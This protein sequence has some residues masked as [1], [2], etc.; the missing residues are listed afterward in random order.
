MLKTILT[1][2]LEAGLNTLIEAGFGKDVRALKE[3]LFG[4]DAQSKR[5]RAFNL[6]FETALQTLP[7][8][9]LLDD[10]AF[11][12]EVVNALLDPQNGFNPQAAAQKFIQE[13]PQQTRHL[14]RFFNILEGHLLADEDWGELLTRYQEVRFREDVLATLARRGLPTGERPAIQHLIATEGSALTMGGGDA[15]AAGGILIKGG[16][17]GNVTI[18]TAPNPHA[19]EAEKMEKARHRYLESLVRDCQFLPLVDLGRDP[20]TDKDVTLNDVYIALDTTHRVPVEEKKGKGKQNT[21]EPSMPAFE[22]GRGEKDRPFTAL[23]AT[24]QTPRLALL[25]D[26]GSGKSTFARHLLA[27]YAGAELG[28]LKA[29]DSL[30]PGLLPVLITLRDLV[31]RL[32]QMDFS[33]MGTNDQ[34]AAYLQVV[35]DQ[36]RADLTRLDAEVFT[37]GLLAHLRAGTCLLVL[38]GLDE[39]PQALQGHIRATVLTLCQHYAPKNIL[40]TCRVRSY[41]GEA[42]QPGFTAYTL[43]PFTHAQIRAFIQQ[44]YQAQASLGRVTAQEAHSKGQ[45]LSAAAVQKHLRELASN[46]MMLTAMAIVHQ[47]K[48]ALPPERVRLYKLVVEVLLNRWQKRKAGTLTAHPALNALLKDDLKLR[49][50]M[51]RLAYEAHLL[52]KQETA[53]A[54]LSRLAALELLEEPEYIGDLTLGQ[55]FLDYVDQRAGLLVGR[56]GKPG[57]PASYSFPHRTFQEY[58]AGCYLTT[59]ASAAEKLAEHA[60]EAEYWSLAVELGAEEIYYNTGTLGLKSLRDLLY[61][62]YPQ[63]SAPTTRARRRALWASKMAVRLGQEALTR[64]PLRDGAVMLTHFRTTL[65]SLLASDL[66]PPERAD[67]GRALAALGDPRPEVMERDAMPFCFVPEGKFTMGEQEKAHEVTLPAYWM[68][69]FPVTSAQY[70]AFVEAGGY[71]NKYYWVEAEK[72]GVW[73]DGKVKGFFDNVPRKS[74]ESFGSPFNLPNHPVVGV[75]WYECLAYTRWL[76]E[77]GQ[78]AGWLA[79][80]WHVTLPSEAEWEKAARGGS[81]IPSIPMSSLSLPLAN[82]L[83]PTFPSPLLPNPL[84]TRAYPWGDEFDANSTNTTESRIETTSA[85]G[86][87]PGGVSPYGVEEMSGNVWEWTRS[88]YK[89]YPYDPHD[90]RENLADKENG[91][92][93][94]GGAFF[95]LSG[96][97]RCSVRGYGTPGYRSSS[98]GF[99]LVV[100]PSS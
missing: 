33:T 61:Q 51:E 82:G 89:D 3:G 57:H 29:P 70:N 78:N 52:G 20:D 95:N 48:Y 39:V 49:R 8:H 65:V 92:V 88:I 58:L 14:K 85:V 37:D 31:P 100:S 9:A 73:K 47:Q 35:R 81:E 77:R 17:G 34:E 98:G 91:R 32:N 44:W 84:P 93:L 46:P 24:A 97:A 16:V 79:R 27:W 94:R 69:R 1:K 80:G 76:T 55:A 15:V 11:Q 56:G 19:V 6:A 87:F 23:E 7:E 26:P 4:Q 66:T 40:L 30:P 36:L 96:Y 74:P 99:R 83:L 60:G 38:D 21:A 71:Q 50:I 12:E 10:P 72:A 53:A 43:S 90:G 86:C 41:V 22:G 75:T 54:D 2:T 42:E 45:D 63:T 28:H 25:G 64:D 18:T 67:A 59:H 68:A 62:L 5:E 13:N